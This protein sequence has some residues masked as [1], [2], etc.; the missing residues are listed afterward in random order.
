VWDRVSLDGVIVI[1]PMVGDPALPVLRERR[2]PFVTV[3]R[4]PSN[5]GPG[6][7][8]VV[9]DEDRGTREVLDH[10]AGRGAERIGLFSVPPLNAFLADTWSCYHRW[11]LARD[12]PP[13]VWEMRLDAFGE[14]RLAAITEAVAAFV[15]RDR[16][17]AIYAPL[18]I[19]GVG[20]QE[21]LRS[22]G[23]RVPDDLMTATTYDAGRSEA[24]DPPMTTLRFDSAEMGRRAAAMLLDMIDGRLDPPVVEVV[25]T[26][27]EPR[28][29]TAG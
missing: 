10:F 20:V 7:A 15:E 2:I 23:L 29:S 24:A 9:A 1:D 17:D 27:L 4:D 5:E 6:D 14:D 26:R 3:G 13:I 12:R 28:A 18:E 8:T 11:C 22:L 25:P 21:A 19:L 16:P